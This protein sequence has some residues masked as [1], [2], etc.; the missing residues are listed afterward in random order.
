AVD[1]SGKYHGLTANS[2]SSVSLDPP[3]ILWSQ[4]FTA[5]SHPVFREAE[6]FAVN[7]LAED[8]IEISQRFA[9]RNVDKFAGVVNRLGLGGVPLIAGCAAYIE[10]ARETIISGGDHAIFLGRVLRIEK[11]G[12]KSLAF[13]SGRYMTAQPHEY[14]R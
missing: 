13:G 12:R 10:C 8:Q 9:T 6:R 1:A 4:S 3:L 2:F 5:P 11:T 14:G 7:V